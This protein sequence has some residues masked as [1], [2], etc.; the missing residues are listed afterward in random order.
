[1]SS[2]SLEEVRTTTGMS[3]VRGSARIRCSTSMPSSLGSLRSSRTTAGIVG[4]SR[5]ACLPVPNRKSTASWPSLATMT[6]LAML[7]LRSARSVSSSSFALSSTSM[8]IFSIFPPL[9]R[10]PS[11]E[12]SCGRPDRAGDQELRHRLGMNGGGKEIPLRLIATV[13]A[14]EFQLLHGLDSLGDHPHPERMRERDH[15]LGDR[16]VLPVPVGLAHE[17]SV[18]LKAIDRQARE[19]AQVRIAGAEIVDGD[20]HPQLLQAIKDGDRPLAALDQ[21]AFGEL[22]LEIARLEA[23]CSQGALDGLH[24]TGTAELL[25][26]DVHG[27][28]QPGERG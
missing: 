21:H 20:L 1:M 19:V 25:R 23:R 22:E 11:V 6:L 13:H 5:P 27:E 18:D 4:G 24:E 12:F 16:S 3:L 7:A 10:A 26:R 15:H 2:S 17:R 28:P 14:Q 9:R 8:I